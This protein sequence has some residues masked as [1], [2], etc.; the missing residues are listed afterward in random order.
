MNRYISTALAVTSIW[1]GLA[2]SASAPTTS[3]A[4]AQSPQATCGLGP[5][6]RPSVPVV[7]VALEITANTSA[8][9]ALEQE[10]FS[11]VLKGAFT[12][13]A[14]VVVTTIGATPTDDTVS[15]ASQAQGQGPNATWIDADA[16]CIE[17]NMERRFATL[18]DTSEAGTP[19]VIGGLRV[20]ADHLAPLHPSSTSVIILGPGVPLMAPLDLADPAVLASDPAKGSSAIGAA[21]L[22]PHGHWEFYLVGLG[23]GVG[24]FSS[25]N[26]DSLESWW[27]WLAHQMGGSLH[28]F[29]P[30]ALTLFPAPVI[31]RP[32]TPKS[33]IIRETPEATS[34][35]IPS[36]LAFAF[37]SAALTPAANPALD[38]ILATLETHPGSTA[39]IDGFTDS[40]GSASFNDSLSIQRADAVAAWIQ[41][42]GV[43]SIRLH[44]AGYGATHFVATNTTPDGRAQNRR[45]SVTI[46]TNGS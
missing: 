28:A 15:L 35:M 39:Q 26:L 43:A 42:A 23:N 33:L 8:L 45:V 14:D 34:I 25:T 37:G 40:I 19:D 10:A 9:G 29:D 32:P 38:Q 13:H 22:L 12:Q 44:T 21:G 1:G 46:E 18:S 30:T 27:W 6:A 11:T 41:G 5:S 7:A 2:L 24:G 3:V 17:K 16:S 31:T 4:G 36:D 20:L